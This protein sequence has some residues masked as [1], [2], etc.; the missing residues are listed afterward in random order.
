MSFEIVSQ[1]QWEE[2]A[3]AF[4]AEHD[5]SSAVTYEELKKFL[6]PAR[7]TRKS[8]GYDFKSPFALEIKAGKTYLMPTGFKCNF[9]SIRLFMSRI[10]KISELTCSHIDKL[11]YSI[12]Q[13]LNIF[14]ALYPRSSYGFKY[15]FQ[16]LNT[17]G[18]IDDDYYNNPSNEGHIMVGFKC[19]KDFD[20]KV[21][22]KFCQGIFQLYT[23]DM[24]EDTSKF[25]ERIGGM[26]STGN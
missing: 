3:R 19:E 11:D 10:R 17:T 4:V 7:S 6:L 2:S 21:E 24:D 23:I 26:G 15:G 8:A 16:L 22:D 5:F 18:I 9:N 13:D 1:E 12:Y 20:I 25:K 14:L